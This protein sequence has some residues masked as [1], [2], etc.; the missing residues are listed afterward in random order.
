MMEY[1]EKFSYGAILLTHIKIFLVDCP[2]PGICGY[3]RNFFLLQM[4]HK[5]KIENQKIV[6]KFY[7]PSTL[8]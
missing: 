2:G 4:T 5:I 7:I 8:S 6:R 3:N 1:G